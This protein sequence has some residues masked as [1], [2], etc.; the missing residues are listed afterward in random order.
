MSQT[1]IFIIIAV[2]VVVIIII[3]IIIVIII[4]VIIIIIIII[5]IV[6]T[7]TMNF[8]RNYNTRKQTNITNNKQPQKQ[9]QYGLRSVQ[10]SSFR[11]VFRSKTGIFTEE[12]KVLLCGADLHSHNAYR[13][14]QLGLILDPAKFAARAGRPRDN[15]SPRSHD[16]DLRDSVVDA[17]SQLCQGY[18]LVPDGVVSLCVRCTHRVPQLN[19]HH[20]PGKENYADWQHNSKKSER[21]AR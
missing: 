12:E 3:I 7:I 6:I 10:F 4:I 15:N 20:F 1:V 17:E 13:G 16:L 19:F 2:V 14:A 5:I 18:R 11:H 21:G 8:F 9:K